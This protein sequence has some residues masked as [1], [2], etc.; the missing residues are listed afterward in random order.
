M[1][2][3]QAVLR[4]VVNGRTESAGSQP[5]K[6][7]TDFVVASGWSPCPL[8][9]CTGRPKNKSHQSSSSAARGGLFH[10][11][12]PN[13]LL[14]VFVRSNVQAYAPIL[15]PFSFYLVLC[16]RDGGDHDV[17]QR[18]AFLEVQVRRMNDVSGIVLPDSLRTGGDPGTLSVFLSRRVS[19]YDENTVM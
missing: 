19:L 15:E 14:K 3:T 5:R 7:R 11:L 17:R 2:Q 12:I 13:I 9:G 8:R 16:I 4:T 6:R 10:Y 18:K 1:L